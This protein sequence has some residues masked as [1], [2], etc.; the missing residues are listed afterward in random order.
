[1]L[2]RASDVAGLCYPAFGTRRIMETNREYDLYLIAQICT[3]NR[4]SW[5][6]SHAS[7]QT[8]GQ[9]NKAHASNLK[10]KTPRYT[11]V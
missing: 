10:K 7:Q 9:G 5:G 11:S 1:M 6:K 4:I 3:F 8:R 2:V